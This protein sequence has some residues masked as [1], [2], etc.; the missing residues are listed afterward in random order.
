MFLNRQVLRYCPWGSLRILVEFYRPPADLYADLGESEI[1]IGEKG[2]KCELIYTNRYQ[3]LHVAALA[4]E[5]PSVDFY[6]S[7]RRIKLR[8]KLSFVVGEREVLARIYEG[9]WEPFL[10]KTPTGL[11]P[12][13]ILGSYSCPADLPLDRP[14]LLRVSVVEA[15]QDLKHEMGDARIVVWRRASM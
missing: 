15:D 9:K 1:D 13:L 14:V 5:H 11:I 10:R 8:L 3:D 7:R 6:E 12:G 2:A 4:F